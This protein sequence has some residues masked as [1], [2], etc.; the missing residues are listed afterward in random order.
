MFLQR[1]C[2]LVQRRLDRETVVQALGLDIHAR[3][4]R[5]AQFCIGQQAMD[6]GTQHCP[7][8]VYRA[9]AAAIRE[10]GEG[11]LR[12]RSAGL[13]HM[14][15]IPLKRC[16]HRHPAHRP[17]RLV[18]VQR[19]FDIKQAKAACTACRAFKSIGIG[20]AVSKHLIAAAQPQNQPAAPV[21]RQNINIP[22][23]PAQSC[24]IGDTRLRSGQDDERGLHRDRLAGR[25]M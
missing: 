17:Q 3:K 11:A 5:A 25:T 15:L 4:K 9:I 14:H 22:A 8:R 16:A 12:I 21:V 10:P 18:R 6:V 23:L 13:A 7:R 19:R 2:D 20:D 1:R 24:Q